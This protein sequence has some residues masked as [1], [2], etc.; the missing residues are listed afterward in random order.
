MARFRARHPESKP[1]DLPGSPQ[2]DEDKARLAEVEKAVSD[3][4]GG[5]VPNG[6]RIVWEPD[7]IYDAFYERANGTV[8]VNAA[9]VAPGMEGLKLDHETGHLLFQD[10]HFRAAFEALWNA[11][12]KLQRERIEK[13]VARDAKEGHYRPE[14]IVEEQRVRALEAIRLM[15]AGDH[16]TPA[17]KRAWKKFVKAVA[18]A[19][20]RLVGRDPVDPERLAAAMLEVGVERLRAG[21]ADGRMRPLD[22][23]APSIRTSDGRTLQGPPSSPSP[24]S[25]ARRTR[26][27]RRASP[28]PES[29]RARGLRPMAT[30]ST[31]RRIGR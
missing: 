20:R 1:P 24:P 12:P 2:T 27:G 10:P 17:V 30:G 7:A 18:D 9:K 19:W 28:P 3:Y 25:T 8:V 4:F 11:L 21:S 29:A 5:D 22:P 14:D 16:A 26:S 6:V 13:K 31:S 15:A 23:D